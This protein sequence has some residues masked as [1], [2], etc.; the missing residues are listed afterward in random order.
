MGDQSLFLSEEAELLRWF[1]LP[2]EAQL[3]LLGQPLPLAMP[4]FHP[5]S[6]P[7]QQH[8]LS[9]RPFQP[10]TTTH[11]GR[12]RVEVERTS[13]AVSLN[14]STEFSSGGKLEVSKSDVSS[15]GKSDVSSAE[16]HAKA[17]Q[18]LAQVCDGIDEPEEKMSSGI[19]PSPHSGPHS[20][21]TCSE[22]PVA[23][24]KGD[25]CSPNDPQVDQGTDSGLLDGRPASGHC[26][27]QLWSSRAA[28]GADPSE[29]D[30]RH[31]R[32]PGCSCERVREGREEDEADHCT[33]TKPDGTPKFHCPPKRIMKPTI[34]V[35]SHDLKH[36]EFHVD[37]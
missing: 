36:H 5:K 37:L 26:V 14:S 3:H 28:D 1:L 9:P 13:V 35:W 10:T 11:S 15:A 7:G 31:C 19:E 16:R 4:P 8:H 20:S 33:K 27:S 21:G 12:S 32:G 29:G 25:V 23:A 24:A 22:Q 30:V 2:S 18:L 17:I 6:Y 34:E